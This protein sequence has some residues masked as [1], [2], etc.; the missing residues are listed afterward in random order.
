MTR[1]AKPGDD[2]AGRTDDEINRVPQGDE[3]VDGEAIAAAADE[4]VYQSRAFPSG[5]GEGGPDRGR[6]AGPEA[7]DAGTTDRAGTPGG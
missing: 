4:A 3:P 2:D 5:G 7:T 6:T 1:T